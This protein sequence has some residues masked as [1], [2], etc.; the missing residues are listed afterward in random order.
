[1]LLLKLNQPTHTHKIY[2]FTYGIPGIYGTV[3]DT[4][5]MSSYTTSKSG[6][7]HMTSAAHATFSFPLMN[8]KSIPPTLDMHLFS[9]H[10][11][12]KKNVNLNNQLCTILLL[13]AL[14]SQISV[15]L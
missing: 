15:E 6:S 2:K 4:I 13:Y 12:S 14:V 7:S 3:T 9:A 11:N 5:L 1:M 8:D 10:R